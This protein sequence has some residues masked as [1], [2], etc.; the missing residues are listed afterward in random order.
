VRRF[1][2]KSSLSA[3]LI[4]LT[5]ICLLLTSAGALLVV[6]YVVASRHGGPEGIGEG[7]YVAS[8]LTFVLCATSI[9]GIALVMTAVRKLLL[10]PVAA[11]RDG[12][13]RVIDGE[14]QPQSARMPSREWGNLRDT[15]NQMVGGLQEAREA[16]AVSQRVL[17]ER[18]ATVDRLLDFSQTIQGAGQAEQV[19]N[20][21]SQF[22]ESELKLS[23]IAILSHQA[24]LLPP[25]QVRASR[26]LNVLAGANPVT[27]MNGAMCPCLRQNLPRQFKCDGSPVRCAIEA[28]LSLPPTHPAYCIPFNVG[29]HM[30]VVV[31]MLLPPAESWTEERRHLAQT[32]VNTAVSSLISLHLLAEAE[33]QSMTDGLT[34]LY[35]RRSMESL[36]QREVALAER[37]THAL[38]IVMI[39]LDRF[40]QVNDVHGHAAGD[41]LLKSFADCV[42]ITLRKTDLAFRF[43]GDEFVIALPQTPVGQAQQVVEKLRQAFASVDFTHA[44]TQLDSQPTLSIG[45]AEREAGNHILTLENLMA[46]ADQALYEAKASNRNCVKIYTPPKAA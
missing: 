17:A 16:H 21:L 9:L 40:K 32:Y 4:F 11:L 36:L 2:A 33:K 23:G 5:A 46:A 20:T 12:M 18:T 24:E 3:Q 44:I 31:H 41:H 39:D 22:L 14:L 25:V 37:H 28:S 42:R 26:P 19:F 27:D 8:K 43:G 13:S 35:N 30:Q 6:Q 34:G 15:F 29:R 10:E 7:Q 38:S 45:V 1:F